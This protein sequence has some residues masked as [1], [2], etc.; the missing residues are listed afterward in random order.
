MIDFEL[1]KF[2][3]K[4]GEHIPYKSIKTHIKGNTHFIS[5][6]IN[7]KIEASRRD[8]IESLGY[9]LIYFMKGELPWS[10]ERKIFDILQM[11][12]NTNLDIL[13]EGLPDEF[14]E[15]IDYGRK[16]RFEERPDYSYLK[17]LLIKAAEKNGIDLDNVEYDWISLE[18]KKKEASKKICEKDTK[19]NMMNFGEKEDNKEEKSDGNNINMI[20]N[21]KDKELKVEEDIQVKKNEEMDKKEE[22][23]TEGNKNG[24]IGLNKEKVKKEER[25]EENKELV[26]EEIND[27]VNIREKLEEEKQSIEISQK[28]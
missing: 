24:N 2:Y 22:I 8:D 20:V 13:C 19:E 15:F 12:M 23:N 14:K 17:K 7:E 5:I 27:K 11:K 28:K 10:K 6:N 4:N 9:N 18:R 3:R 21:E 16:L 25:K 26:N 1:A